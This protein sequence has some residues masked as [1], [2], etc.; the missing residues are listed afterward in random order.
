VPERNETIARV[1]EPVVAAL[2]LELY[3]LDL[4]GQ[5]R[6]QTLRVVVDRDGGVDLDAITAVAEAVSPVLDAEAPDV[7]RGPY[8][9]EVTSPGLERALRTPAHFR[10]AAGATVS[11]KLRGDDGVARR[12]RGVL[13]TADDDGIVVAIQEGD[14]EGA[15]ERAR[16]DDIIQARTVFEWGPAPKPHVPK[17]KKGAK[18]QKEAARS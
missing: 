8:A 3:D 5:G 12:V 16:Y 6:A 18:K 13:T 1:V 10:R 11:V 7:V 9:L 4:T 2:G 17:R 14:G 15:M